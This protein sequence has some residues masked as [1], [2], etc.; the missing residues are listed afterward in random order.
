MPRTLYVDGSVFVLRHPDKNRVVVKGQTSVAV[1][2]ITIPQKI[3]EKKAD[4][5]PKEGN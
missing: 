3:K 2:F 5:K 4:K 1:H